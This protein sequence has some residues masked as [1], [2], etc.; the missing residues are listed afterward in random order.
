MN[1]RPNLT[2]L[3]AGA[4][5]GDILKIC[6]EARREQDAFL[7]SRGLTLADA[8]RLSEKEKIELTAAYQRR[9]SNG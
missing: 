9:R 5:A 4:I 1:A 8:A 6:L 3:A 2:Y 7:A